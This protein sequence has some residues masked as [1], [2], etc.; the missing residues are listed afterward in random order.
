MEN[1]PHEGRAL[2]FVLFISDWEL[3]LDLTTILDGLQRDSD[4]TDV[5]LQI[6]IFEEL[7][8]FI[9]ED[10]LQELVL[11]V[12]AQF[13]GLFQLVLLTH[14]KVRVISHGI[15]RSKSE[16]VEVEAEERL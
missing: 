11:E 6:G 13:L 7:A 10:N 1:Q 14:I 5:V 3:I 16:L 12:V 8:T 15:F 9:S 2:L 4:R